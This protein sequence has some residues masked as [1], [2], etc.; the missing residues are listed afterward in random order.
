MFTRQAI[1]RNWQEARPYLIFATILFFASVVVG[2]AS[3]GQVE[4]LDSTIGNL[5]EIAQNVS[6]SDH[7]RQT[8]FSS[9]AVNNIYASLTAMFIGIL[10]GIMPIITLITNGMVLGYLFKGLAD[11]G[12]NIGLLIVQ[13]ILPHGILEIPALLFACGYGVRLGVQVIKGIF[14]SLMGKTAPWSGFAFALKGSF[15][16]ALLLIVM[17]LA[18]ALVESTITYGIMARHPV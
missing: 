14:G 13:G 10:G 7:P 1:V 6:Q 17:L 15:P 9:I 8:M 3:Q 5:K 4:W 16:A 2:G 11:Q 12:E 18:A